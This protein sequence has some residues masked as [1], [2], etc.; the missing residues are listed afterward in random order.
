MNISIDYKNLFIIR[1]PF[2][3]LSAQEAVNHFKLNNNHLIVVLNYNNPEKHKAQL[4]NL[5]DYDFWDTVLIYEEKKGSNFFQTLKYIKKL[6][7][8]K[9][10]YVFIKNSFLANDQ[11]L[12]SNIVYNKLILLEDGTITF[13]LID[14][15]I[16]NKPLFSFKKKLYRFYLLGLNL[17]KKYS[18]EIFTM[19][20]LPKLKGYKVHKH[21]FEYLR[22]KYEIESKD[23]SKDKIFIIGQQHVE[24]KYLSLET[25]LG[26]IEAI[27]KKYPHCKII[28]MMHRKELEDKF[29]P[30]TSK[31]KNL[32]ILKSDTM[33]ELY[34]IQLNYQPF[35]IIG[36]ASTL[37][38][39]LKKF[40]PKLDILSYIFE[41]NEIL[42]EHE[43]FHNN[44]K[45]FEKEKIKFVKKKDF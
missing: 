13:R 19:F 25:Y 33:G 45:S 41:D 23:K 29:E 43:W 28:Y 35:M 30:L 26:F 8:E 12:L 21:N 18:F 44:Y 40:F 16:N 31:Y 37:L 32:E 17:K 14:R 34:F 42:A 39:S 6:K 20:D 3:L 9:F 7:K 27:I 1:F 15:I 2:Q 5:I 36:T 10:N 24:T 4:K 38:F 22:K 11:L